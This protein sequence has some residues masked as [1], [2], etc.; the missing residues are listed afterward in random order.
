MSFVDNI[1]DVADFFYCCCSCLLVLGWLDVFASD[2]Q[3][4][5]EGRTY[6]FQHDFPDGTLCLAT[7][8]P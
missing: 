5:G 4:G 1:T 8:T 6:T 3:D 2:G 7:F